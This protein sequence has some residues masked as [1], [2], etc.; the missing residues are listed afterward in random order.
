MQNPVSNPKEL[1]CIAVDVGRKLSLN[2]GFAKGDSGGLVARR[3]RGRYEAVG[4]ISAGD[5]STITYAYPLSA[6]PERLL[7]ALSED[8]K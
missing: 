4:I 2:C 3:V 6:L 1:T 8:G 5:S 7:K